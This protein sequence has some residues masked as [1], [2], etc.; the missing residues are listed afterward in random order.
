MRY[1]T[2]LTSRKNLNL[3]IF[4]HFNEII[5]IEENKP[6]ISEYSTKK[7]SW[8]WVPTL[9]EPNRLKKAKLITEEALAGEINNMFVKE[10]IK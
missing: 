2:N 9:I 10:H 4:Y 8:S 5:K 6:F 7:N 1:E 3:I